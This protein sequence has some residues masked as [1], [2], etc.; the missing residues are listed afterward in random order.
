MALTCKLCVPSSWRRALAR[1]CPPPST[2]THAGWIR[3]LSPTGPGLV[4]N[5]WT[6]G[7]SAFNDYGNGYTA[8]LQSM[9]LGTLRYPGGEKSDSC[10]P[11]L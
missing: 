10:V 11:A 8:A 5:Y 7:N 6:D 4:A 1:P 9:N 3:T 2:C